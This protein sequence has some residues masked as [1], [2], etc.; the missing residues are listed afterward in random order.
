MCACAYKRNAMSSENLEI[1]MSLYRYLYVQPRPSEQTS[2]AELP[3]N[4]LKELNKSIANA[5]QSKGT[6]ARRGSDTPKLLQLKIVLPLEG[7]LLKMAMR[8]ACT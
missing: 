2:Q 4:V 3:E 6:L 7:T 1:E 8:A 5:L